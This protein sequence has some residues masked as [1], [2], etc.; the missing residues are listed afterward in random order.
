[1]LIC[2]SADIGL[3]GS[4]VESMNACVQAAEAAA[5]TFPTAAELRAC[6][7]TEGVSMECAQCWGNLFTDFRSCYYDI[8]DLSPNTPIDAELPQGCSDCLN[9]LGETY[10][11][12]ESFCG[13]SVA[14]AAAPTTA[15]LEVVAEMDRWTHS[16]NIF[17]TGGVSSGP[18]S[19][20]IVTVTKTILVLA[21][22][23]I[24][25]PI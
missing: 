23:V 3:F 14:D 22:L 2:S 10:N 20:S 12:E 5:E 21:V 25:L 17:T 4:T 7:T 19:P 13:V 1:M 8:C 11:N 9:N 15:G 6:M 18:S 24:G 16:S